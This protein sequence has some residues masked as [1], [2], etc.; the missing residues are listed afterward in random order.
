MTGS[1]LYV[2][3]N[4]QRK[5][6]SSFAPFFTKSLE[7][8]VF[9]DPSRMEPEDK[10][11]CRWIGFG[12]GKGITDPDKD[13]T[14]FGIPT[15]VTAGLHGMML[16]G[17]ENTDAPPL[18]YEEFGHKLG[19]G[20]FTRWVYFANPASCHDV[21]GIDWSISARNTSGIA[22]SMVRV[23]KLLKT[24]WLHGIPQHAEVALV[25][26]KMCEEKVIRDMLMQTGLRYI[27]DW[28]RSGDVIFGPCSPFCP[29]CGLSTLRPESK[30]CNRCGCDPRLFWEERRK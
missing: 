27:I 4:E 5:P 6:V 7:K 24:L 10:K 21:I 26:W 17:F 20:G 1:G 2:W 18:C 11:H 16:D 12:I 14:V 25:N 13:V 9:M 23:T 22:N 29:R 8:R 30:F 28:V 3:G 19:F 15:A